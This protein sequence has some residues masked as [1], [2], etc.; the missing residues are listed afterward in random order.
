MEIGA[1]LDENKCILKARPVR[2]VYLKF[3]II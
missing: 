2:I 1:S 3:G